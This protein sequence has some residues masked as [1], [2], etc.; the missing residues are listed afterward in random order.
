MIGRALDA[1]EPVPEWRR[2]AR[3]Q[4]R[5][6]ATSTVVLLVAV[7]LLL[8]FDRPLV[9][10]GG[11]SPAF[12]GNALVRTVHD[13]TVVCTTPVVAGRHAFDVFFSPA[14]ARSRTPAFFGVASGRHAMIG[15]VAR[16]LEAPPTTSGSWIWPALPSTN[17]GISLKRGGCGRTNAHVPLARSRLPGPPIRYDHYHHCILNG[18]LLIRARVVRDGTGFRAA[19]AVRIERTRQPIAFATI[20]RDETGGVYISNRCTLTS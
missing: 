7:G 12:A 6:L 3:R 4:A 11:A 10:P 1:F 17:A 19:L 13:T 8:G 14:Y 9:R 18:R 5:A 15:V 20:A 16:R 2:R